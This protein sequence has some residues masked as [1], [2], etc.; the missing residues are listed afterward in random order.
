[1]KIESLY[2]KKNP[3]ISFELFPPRTPKGLENMKTTIQ[4]LA[5]L[6]PDFI[7]VTCHNHANVPKYTQ[8]MCEEVQQ[9]GI[10]ALAHLSAYGHTEETLQQEVGA[11]KEAGITNILALR[12]DILEPEVSCAVTSSTELLTFIND[13]N[14]CCGATCYPLPHPESRGVVSDFQFLKAKQESGAQFLISQLFFDND[15]YFA[16]VE[17]ARLAGVDI[18]ISAGIMPVTN[19]RQVE[20]ICQLSG[21]EIPPK[22]KRILERYGDNEKQLFEAGIAYATEQIFDLMTRGVDG[23]H[24]YMLNN[25][26]IS[27]RLVS[28]IRKMSEAE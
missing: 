14:V 10:P 27:Q 19:K 25:L 1:M 23:I 9:Y 13:E 24:L 17:K 22:Y 21:V 2:K 8:V 4:E 12:G 7:S 16:F 11:L 3:V 18:P 20:R 5:S 15:Q 26:E 6:H 28:S